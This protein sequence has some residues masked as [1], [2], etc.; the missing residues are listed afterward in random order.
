M[1]IA[2]LWI[3]K[4]MSCIL[5]FISSRYFKLKAILKFKREF[6]F[7]APKLLG[8][9]EFCSNPSSSRGSPPGGRQEK[10]GCGGEST[11]TGIHLFGFADGGTPEVSST[12]QK[13]SAAASPSSLFFVSL[14]CPI[15][16]SI[17]IKRCIYRG[18]RALRYRAGFLLNNILMSP[19]S[20]YYIGN[21]GYWCCFQI[22]IL[23]ALKMYWLLFTLV[24]MNLL[25]IL[26]PLCTIA[27][28]INPFVFMLFEFILL[29]H[30]T[31]LMKIINSYGFLERKKEELSDWTLMQL[32]LTY[33]FLE[34]IFISCW[35]FNGIFNSIH[36]S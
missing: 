17:L 25:N 9:G 34:E 18:S 21:W 33:I 36:L 12:P 35:Y 31:M 20:G 26:F 11:E 7:L 8:D 32:F 27:A 13:S 29:L 4:E 16:S 1:Q 15:S 30:A 3:I 10:S 6:C 2:L 23:Q 24:K 19:V 5:A 22:K 28:N 14:S